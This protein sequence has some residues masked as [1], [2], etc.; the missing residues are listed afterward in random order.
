MS[1]VPFIDPDVSTATVAEVESVMRN[2]GAWDQD[3]HDALWWAQR[4]DDCGHFENMTSGDWM[5]IVY[6]VFRCQTD[7]AADLQRRFRAAIKEELGD[8]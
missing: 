2:P 5:A 1:A 7:W 4:L 6:A 3:G 8:E